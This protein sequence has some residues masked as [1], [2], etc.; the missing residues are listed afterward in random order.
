MADAADYPINSIKAD[1]SGSGHFAIR[2]GFADGRD[3]RV[4]SVNTAPE[5]DP[6]YV[7]HDD[8]ADWTDLVAASAT[9]PVVT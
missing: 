2:T 1:P 5:E 4:I 3:W 9:T 8:I 6:N 7:A